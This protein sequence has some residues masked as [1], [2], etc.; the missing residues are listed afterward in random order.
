M[1]VAVVLES[2]AVWVVGT[3][4]RGV[5]VPSEACLV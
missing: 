1:D 2:Y 4:K 3:V 5:V